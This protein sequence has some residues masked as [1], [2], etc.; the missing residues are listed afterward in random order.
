MRDVSRWTFLE[1]FGSTG[2]SGGPV[3]VWIWTC[4][5]YCVLVVYDLN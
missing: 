2:Y 3:M 5:V 1:F 4:R